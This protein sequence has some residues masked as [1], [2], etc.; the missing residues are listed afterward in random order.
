M[1]PLDQH[2]DNAPSQATT[3]PRPTPAEPRLGVL[4]ADRP[5]ARCGF[6]L[7]G[8]TIIR[9]PHYQL[10]SARCPECGQLAAL[11]EYPSLSAWTGRAR[12]LF[13]A[14]FVAGALAAILVTGLIM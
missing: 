12:L 2:L 7:H 10:V 6:N 13:A 5:C 4:S 8:A 14:Q 1:T 9:E 3:A 11:Q